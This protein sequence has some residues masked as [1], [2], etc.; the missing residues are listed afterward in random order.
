MCTHELY[1]EVRCS[2]E[3]LGADMQERTKILVIEDEPVL[4][5]DMVQTL[6]RTGFEVTAATTVT[7]ALD[8]LRLETFDVVVLDLSLR[9][10]RA[11]PIA[12]V[13]RASGTPYVICSGHDQSDSPI[14]SDAVLC[15]RKPIVPSA[16]VDA[17]KIAA[18]RHRG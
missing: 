14:W 1:P 10:R 12:D 3:E 4:L 5:M 16:L 2:G 18:G 15:L 6:E 8:R 9:G 13:L 11:D 17:V 7:G